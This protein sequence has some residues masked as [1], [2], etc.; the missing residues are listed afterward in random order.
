MRRPSAAGM[1]CY[2][3]SDGETNYSAAFNYSTFAKFAGS[4]IRKRLLHLR[5]A[6]VSFSSAPHDSPFFSHFLSLTFP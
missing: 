2:I 3:S 4:F 6:N 1:R 5:D